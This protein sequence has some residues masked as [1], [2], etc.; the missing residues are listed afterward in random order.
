MQRIAC[1]RYPA[2]PEGQDTTSLET[3]NTRGVYPRKAYGWFFLSNTAILSFLTNY[4]LLFK[5]MKDPGDL[6]G[7]LRCTSEVIIS[8]PRL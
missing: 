1:K 5:V 3:S 2:E 6:V 7:C 4:I 8:K